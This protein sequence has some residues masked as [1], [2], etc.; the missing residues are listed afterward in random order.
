MH[1]RFVRDLSVLALN[2]TTSSLQCPRCMKE[3]P[4]AQTPAQWNRLSV[5]TTP[6]GIQVW[7]E[8]HDCNV[9]HITVTSE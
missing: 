1:V 4:A 6:R 8:R 2:E 7:C 3:R 5:G 9:A